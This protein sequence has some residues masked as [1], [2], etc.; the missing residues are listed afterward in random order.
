MKIVSFEFIKWGNILIDDFIN[1]ISGFNKLLGY[2]KEYLEIRENASGS[3]IL[4]T[5]EKIFLNNSNIYSV[6]SKD[7]GSDFSIGTV[8]EIFFICMARN[9]GNTINYSK[10][11]DFCIE[12]INFEIGGKNKSIKQIK[13]KLDVSFLVKDNILHRTKYEIPLYL[14]GFLY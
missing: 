13:N 12:G 1:D 3:S 6:I 4:K 7:I 2:F 9:S 5:N 8:R 11:G 10:V 14:F